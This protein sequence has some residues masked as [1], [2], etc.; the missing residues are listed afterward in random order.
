MVYAGTIWGYPG[1]LRRLDM[2][3]VLNEGNANVVCSCVDR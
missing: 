3:M 2:A 1:P